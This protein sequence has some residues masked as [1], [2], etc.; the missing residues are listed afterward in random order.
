MTSGCTIRS[1]PAGCRARLVG[2]FALA[3]LLASVAWSTPATA[4]LTQTN[5]S[6]G[7]LTGLQIAIEKQRQRLSSAEVEERRDALMRL[8][9]LH[10]PE[11]SSIALAALT[12]PAPIVRATA[13]S[14]VLALPSGVSAAAL[15]LLLNDGDEFVRREAAYALG[16]TRSRSTVAPLLERLASD[17]KASVR[18]AVVVALGQIGEESAVVQLTQVLLAQQTKKGRPGRSK[19][20]PF[21]LRAAASSLGAI[22]SRAGVPALIEALS[23][24]N[25]PGDVK[26]EAARSLGLIGDPSAVPALRAALAARD[27]HLSELAYAA[28]RRIVP[29]EYRK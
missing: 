19:E 18:G 13:T 3:L 5:T 10:R 15:I 9:G 21:V 16:M 8:G 29:Q 26:R 4:A 27:P 20:N 14:A 24:D 25:M 12:D 6:K 7:S 1:H 23:N 11:A 17:A 2:R 22:G 28:L